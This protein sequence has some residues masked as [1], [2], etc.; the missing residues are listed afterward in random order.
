M[1]AAVSNAGGL[2]SIGA[3]AVN[4]VGARAMIGALKALTNKPFNVNVFTHQP[5]KPDPVRERAWLE[6]L[7]PVFR[8]FGVE[9]PAEIGE[10]YTSFLADP[11]MLELFLETRPAVVSFHFGLPPADTIARLKAAG[12]V[13]LSSATN[14]DEAE[15]AVAAGVDAIV[16]QGY[17]AGG[18][19]GVFDPAAPDSQLGVVV[20]TRLLVRKLSV[21]VIATGG[22]MDG[23]GVA[24]MLDLGAQA[25]QLG[26][27]FIAC[28]ESS[29]DEA[30]HREALLG[31]GAAATE[32]TALIS[33]RPARCLPNAFTALKDGA[34]RGLSPPDYP[35]AYDAGKA[36]AAAARTRGEGGFGAQWAG[37]GAPLARAMPAAQ[38]V[39]ALAEE[40]RM[41]PD[42]PAVTPTP[43]SYGRPDPGGVHC[44]HPVVGGEGTGME[45][46]FSRVIDLLPGLVWTARPDGRADFVNQR[47][48]DY[49]G[50]S[51]EGALG[52]GWQAAA[53]PADRPDFVERW[54]TITAAEAP[55]ELEARLRRADGEYRWFLLRISPIADA[56]GKA[57]RWCGVGTDIDDRKRQAQASPARGRNFEQIVDGLPAII[58]LFTG[59]GKIA[60]CNKQ[61]LEYLDETFEQV[62]AKA[63]AYNFHPA[64]RDQVLARWAA[65]VEAGEPFDFEARLRRADGAYRWQ[66]TRVFPLRDA[67]GRIDLWYG[68]CTDIDDRRWAETLLAGE[69]RLLSMVAQGVP[70][71]DVLAALC[72]VV[73]DA[74]PGRLCSVLF[75][76]PD[77]VRFRHGAGPS[78]PA[79]YNELLDGLVMDRDY[80]PCGMAARLKTQVIAADVASDPRWAASPW[81]GLVLAHGLRS[82]WS[83]PI[84]S[85]D[86][87]VIGVF[88]LYQHQPASPSRRENELIRQFTHIAGVAIERAQSDASLRESEARKAAILDSALDAIVTID[89]EGRITE[90][91][92]AAERTFGYRE[93]ELLGRPIA[94]AIVPPS[95]R[96][97]H[98]HGLA[99]YL[100]GGDARVL[101]QRLEMT[102]MRADG[103]EFPVELAITRIPLEGPPSFTGYLRDISARK[104]AEEELLRSQAFL[105]E[106]QR[107]SLTGSFFWR[108]DTDEITVSKEF[109]RIHGLAPDDAVTLVQI[110]ERF[111]PDDVAVLSDKIA[112]ARRGGGDLDYEVRLR[113][114]D[115]STKHLH[116]VSQSLQGPDGQ[117]EIVGA[118]QDIT[119]R[120][121]AEAELRRSNAFLAEAQRISATG[122]FS[123]RVATDEIAWSEQVYRMF[124]YDLAVPVTLQLLGA[125]IHPEDQPLLDDMV[126]SARRGVSDFEYEHRLLL[127]NGSIKHLHLMAHGAPDQAGQ[128]EYIGAVQEITERRVAEEALGKV[129]SELAHMA[130]VNSLGA[131]TA[132]IAHEV[133]QPLSGI[134]TNASTCLRMLA[135]DP[136]N[137]AGAQETAR[138]TVRDGNRAAD[139]IKRLR[140]LFAKREAAGEPVDLNEAAREVIALSWNDLQRS[141]VIVRLELADGLPPV[142]GDR[143]QL[144]QVILN[145]L[146][147]AADAMK[148]IEDRPRQVTIST[149]REDA[150]GVRLTV[151][152]AGVGL[153]PAATARLFDAFYTT[154]SEGMGIGL[155]VSRTIVENHGGRLWAEANDG[156]GATFAFSI[157]CGSED[158][159]FVRTAQPVVQ[160]AAGDPQSFS[161]KR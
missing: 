61:M 152:D 76:D 120:K 109:R 9:P 121:R 92:P 90:F 150:D 50:M 7:A 25:A 101:G 36:L 43:K 81:P 133:N 159:A 8:R 122:S 89:H 75:I 74:A 141:R 2:G 42:R 153:G 156:P 5:A 19:R 47:W 129:R 18:H 138:R 100:A 70:L 16:A 96:E 15:R 87:K 118:V 72:Q 113:M 37:Q 136:P 56:S 116:T 26:T 20:L 62:H 140:T 117:L 69:K 106:G 51:F 142:T 119:E 95:M 33:G 134:I 151:R 98:R 55:A 65:S 149:E 125:R 158:P 1:A 143:V 127:P 73:E 39:A 91:N 31:P 66:R 97:Q 108:P 40:L 157:P 111:H 85:R 148:E 131:L 145:L 102:A 68:L 103:G 146:L 34:L 80:G 147:N 137:I 24:A 130:R 132:S 86:D 6:A 54:R 154:K 124:E 63:S 64:D 114:P 53:H 115:G 161:V 17:E 35:I 10:I 11:A 93:E 30:Y 144:Q 99:L 135:A 48:C 21:P 83:T 45:I 22:V 4:A 49:T 78:L 57:V 155:S 23:A 38:L 160:S 28:P 3:G 94:E 58:A 67:E 13:L 84:L 60:F 139:I 44:H 46:D 128:M 41:V 71:A 107:L 112:Q 105:A 52:E 82:C 123:W 88:A 79:A 59:D 27:A 126:E 77:G 29:A 14:L 104:R 12:I 32:M 110:R